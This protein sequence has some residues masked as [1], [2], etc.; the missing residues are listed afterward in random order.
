MKR[1]ILL[2]SLFLATAVS[3][4]QK[5]QKIGY[6]D[7]DYI[8]ENVPE[9]VES[10]QKLNE[11]VKKW[12]SNLNKKE[13]EILS[14][15]AS[16]DA[17]RA[18][19]TNDL[20]EEREEDILIKEQ[21]LLELKNA[22]FGSGGDL[23]S[24]RKQLIK[25]VQ[26]QIYNAVQSIAKNKKYD[27]VVDK[28]SDLIMLY[29][30]ERFDISDLV[31]RSITKSKKQVEVEEKQKEKIEQNKEAKEAVAKK[32]TEREAKRAELQARLEK[33]KEERAKIRAEQIKKNEEK[34]QAR[35]K[36]RQELLDKRKQEQQDRINKANADKKET[37]EEDSTPEDG[38]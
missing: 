10:Q 2:I 36:A 15:R 34:K 29:S 13:N 33:Q 17:E 26:D 8:L 24:I 11:K 38:E 1:S 20:V 22:Y 12:E 31:I 5:P 18:L 9:Y 4:A 14:M 27:F 28:S 16:L 7:M 37:P 23:F 3:L 6:I 30:N 19:L 21:E 25:P 32:Q 35:L